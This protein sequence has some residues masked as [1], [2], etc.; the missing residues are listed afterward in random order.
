ML[1]ILLIVVIIGLTIF[2]ALRN[3]DRKSPTSITTTT[4][5]TVE[6]STTTTTTTK[7]ENLEDVYLSCCY[8]QVAGGVAEVSV[9]SSHPI[10]TNLL[11]DVRVIDDFGNT[12]N[13]QISMFN[14]NISVYSNGINLTNG[15]AGV[16][17]CEILNVTPS[18]SS[19]QN[20]VIDY[21]N[22]GYGLSCN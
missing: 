11:I 6:T 5:T 22:P 9:Y 13:S 7:S 17:G 19:T 2:F 15:G 20:Y 14:G 18:S 8:K 10:D 16:S 12:F 4:T 21:N 1:E 3:R